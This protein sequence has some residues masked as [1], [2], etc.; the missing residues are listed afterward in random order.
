MAL[1]QFVS[2]TIGSVILADFIAYLGDPIPYNRTA[3]V[4]I[5]LVSF[6]IGTLATIIKRKAN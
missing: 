1:L 6:T 4:T 2:F 3:Q 5:I